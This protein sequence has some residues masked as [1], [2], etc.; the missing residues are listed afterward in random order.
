MS[1]LAREG[2]NDC[3]EVV[4]KV[5]LCFDIVLTGL[6][7]W[8]LGLF[9]PYIEKRRRSVVSALTSRAKGNRID[10]GRRHETF[11]VRT[12]FPSYH[13]QG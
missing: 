5:D 13:L 7:L 9:S 10:P 6:N 3:L 8:F 4:I 1:C 11:A 2:L 12:R